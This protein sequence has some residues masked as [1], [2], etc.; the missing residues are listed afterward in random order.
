MLKHEIKWPAEAQYAVQDDDGILK[1]VFSTNLPELWDSGVWY[2]GNLSGSD[3]VFGFIDLADDWNIRIITHAE[4]QN[5]GGWMKWEGDTNPVGD[6]YIEAK[7]RDESSYI[8]LFEESEFWTYTGSNTDIVAYRVLQTQEHVTN[9][10]KHLEI[11]EGWQL[12]PVEP[13]IEMVQAATHSAVGFG[14]RA[15]YKAMLAAAPKL[16]NK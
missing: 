11:T 7:L 5:V 8:G 13:T 15:A 3:P 1:W 14:T 4:Y 6:A 16:G 9:H 12:V 2:R 10:M